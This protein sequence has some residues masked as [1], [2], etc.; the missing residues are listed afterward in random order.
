[1]LTKTDWLCWQTFN[2]L[3]PSRVVCTFFVYF[4]SSHKKLCVRTCLERLWLK[5][6]PKCWNCSQKKFS[7][8][9]WLRMSRSSLDSDK[10]FGKKKF[11]FECPGPQFEPWTLS[12]LKRKGTPFSGSGPT[13]APTKIFCKKKPFKKRVGNFDYAYVLAKPSFCMFCKCILKQR[14]SNFLLPLI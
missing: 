9:F 5:V 7:R 11:C 12:G 3:D 4:N 6:Y 2:I 8:G 10:K 1:V 14:K 13:L